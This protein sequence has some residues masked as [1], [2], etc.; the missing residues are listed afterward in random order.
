MI[1]VEVVILK[2]KIICIGKLKEHYLKEAIAE[3]TKRMQAFAKLEIIELEEVR[4]NND[5]EVSKALEKEA[6]LIKKHLNQDDYVIALDVQGKLIDNDKYVRI[7]E[8]ACLSGFSTFTFIIGSSHGLDNAIRNIAKF[9]WS[10]SP[11]VFPH[12]L[13]RVILLEQIYRGFKIQS[14][15]PYHK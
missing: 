14:N 6:E 10:F 15:Q 3:Y 7:I 2:I 5:S 4:I 12:Q 9:K 13:M 1:L 11:L 8:E